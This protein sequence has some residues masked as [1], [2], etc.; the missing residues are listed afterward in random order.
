MTVNDHAILPDLQRIRTIGPCEVW[1]NAHGCW[2]ECPVCG[3]SWP[4]LPSYATAE[5]AE[6]VARQ[7]ADHSPCGYERS[8]T[9]IALEELLAV[10]PVGSYA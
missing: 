8:A 6:D 3:Q 4:R 9:S 2:T 7:H 5:E 10:A 1:L